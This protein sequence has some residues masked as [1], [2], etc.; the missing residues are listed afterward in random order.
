[1]GA[2]DLEF[3]FGG[4]TSPCIF[5]E[6][7]NFSKNLVLYL[8]FRLSCN[9]NWHWEAPQVRKG[10]KPS[11]KFTWQQFYLFQYSEPRRVLSHSFLGFK[12]SSPSNTT[13]STFFASSIARSQPGC[14][15]GE[16]KT[17]SLT[18]T[19]SP[20]FLKTLT[21]WTPRRESPEF[22]M[23]SCGVVWWMAMF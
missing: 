9:D 2:Y 16:L 22:K 11:G 1:M 3:Q 23:L 15:H 8:F 6:L 14:K 17:S 20:A 21:S 7:I 19:Q 4:Q 10:P 18:T 5:K 13:R 12:Q